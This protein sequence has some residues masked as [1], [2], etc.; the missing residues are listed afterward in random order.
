VGEG[1]RPAGERPAAAAVCAV[2]DSTGPNIRKNR[3]P[4]PIRVGNPCLAENR[5]CVSG[6]AEYLV[7]LGRHDEIVL[8]RHDEIVLMQSLNLLGL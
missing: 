5:S 7:N 1:E 3:I 4:N 8:G 2:H 6:T